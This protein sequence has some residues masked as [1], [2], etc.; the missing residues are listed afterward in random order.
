MNEREAGA[1]A[2][3]NF[4]DAHKKPPPKSPSPSQPASSGSN[5]SSSSSGSSSGSSSSGG[6]LPPE[7]FLGFV[8]A[9]WGAILVPPHRPA[10]DPY[11]GPSVEL[12]NRG[13]IPI[14][15]LEASIGGFVAQSEYVFAR[16]FALRLF[17]GPTAFTAAWD[18]MYETPPDPGSLARLDLYRFDVSSDLLATWARGVELYP[19]MGTL[20]L[21]GKRSTWAFDG[22]LEL[23]AYPYRPLT[24]AVSSMAGVFAHGPVLFDT[25][26]EAGVS[27]DRFELRGGIRWL[28]QHHAQSFAG[29][30]GTVVIRL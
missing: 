14:R 22:G 20:L 17:P 8:P 27:Y 12:P 9:L 4:E 3:D 11:Q 30:I 25:Q 21:S 19:R 16:S 26:V 29:P 24:V 10:L 6:T 2:L 28:Y 15:H 7:V 13:G 23:R 5:E 1:G 18:R